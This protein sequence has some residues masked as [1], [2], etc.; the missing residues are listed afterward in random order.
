MHMASPAIHPESGRKGS[1]THGRGQERNHAWHAPVAEAGQLVDGLHDARLRDY[2]PPTLRSA[3][4]A[5][6]AL[7]RFGA[8]R[9]RL[10]R[11][12]GAPCLYSV[13]VKLS[14]ADEPIAADGLSMHAATLRALAEC[15][16]WLRDAGTPAP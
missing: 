13:T 16:G 9:R 14:L 15:E 7:E 10:L 11:V 5:Y 3:G 2:P 8:V 6:S 1:T 12:A 4:L